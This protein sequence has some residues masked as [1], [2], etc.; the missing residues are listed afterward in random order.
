[1]YIYPRPKRIQEGDGEVFFDRNATLTVGSGL[2]TK[3]QKTLVKELYKNFTCGVG[4]LTVCD[5]EDGVAVL[6]KE[7]RTVQGRPFDGE[8]AISVREGHAALFFADRIGFMHAFYTLLSMIE[9]RTVKGSLAFTLPVCEIEDEPTVSFRG[10]HFCVFPETRYTMLKKFIRFAGFAKYTHV[11]IEFWGTFPYRCCPDMARKTAYS[12]KQIKSLVREAND[13]GME[14]VPML[15]CLGHAAQNRALFGKHAALDQNPKLAPYFEP[16]GWT[17]NLLNP[18][19]KQLLK[20]MRRELIEICGKGNYFH[21]GCDEAFPY[22]TSRLFAGRDKN[23]I[24]V[25][26]I[27]DIAKEMKEMGRRIFIW[28]DQMLYRQEGWAP[29]PDN[30][31]YAESQE[32]ADKLLNGLDKD[33]IVTD[34]QYYATEKVMPTAKILSEHGF[35]VILAPFDCLKGTKT[36]VQ[37]VLD[38]GYKGLLQTTWHLMHGGHSDW[39]GSISMNLRSADMFW[40]GRTEHSKMDN[41]M[42]LFH[43]GSLY[44]KLLP[45]KGKYR[46]CGIREEEIDT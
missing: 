23:D 9:E 21:I 34:W 7:A 30:I 14:V 15:N 11:I 26:H 5:G 6:A 28:G 8:Y 45:P 22:G 40:N 3:S 42:L 35:E 39:D 25:E 4:K 10:I 33:I 18:D 2:L 38:N 16:T 32:M 29:P 13:L 1:M 17:W 41:E 24:L 20:E 19:T 44:R 31:A 36:C 43:T 37:N 27:N 12:R 46:D